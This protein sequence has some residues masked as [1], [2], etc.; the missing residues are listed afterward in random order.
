M[1]RVFVSYH[2]SDG[3]DIAH[4]LV[5]GLERAGFQ[6]CYAYNLAEH[7]PPASYEWRQGL[8]SSL[9][10]ADGLLVVTTKGS[11]TAEWCTW[12]IA[13]FRERKPDALVVEF[14]S[15]DLEQGRALLNHR[16]TAFVNRH[17]PSSMD[18]AVATAVRLLSSHG[19]STA[20]GLTSPFP[21]LRTF[22]EGDASIFF[23][24][25]GGNRTPGPPAVGL[26]QER[27]AR[28]GRPLGCGQVIVG[29]SGARAS[30]A[31]SA[32]GSRRLRTDMAR[33]RAIP[34]RGRRHRTG[35]GDRGD[36]GR[37]GAG[38]VHRRGGRRVHR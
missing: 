15:S 30:S 28:R 18:S 27:H 37:H 23:E 11:M 35:R 1:G 5:A 16:Q 19:V 7:G 31:P 21:G 10:G 8:R 38:P 25:A 12:E 36:P 26:T 29:Q 20:P 2:A 32:D 6:D 24:Q 9:L 14:V 17:D 34:A 22:E 4:R 13:V 33:P 3:R